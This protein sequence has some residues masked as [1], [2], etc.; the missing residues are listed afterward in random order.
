MGKKVEKPKRHIVSCRLDDA[1]YQE[2][3]RSAEECGVS[4]SDALRA[5]A[6]PRSQGHE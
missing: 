2:L 4:I 1:E 3:S 6:R 5:A